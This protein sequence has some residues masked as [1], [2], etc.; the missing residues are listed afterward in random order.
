MAPTIDVSNETLERLDKMK[1]PYT[2]RNEQRQSQ[3]TEDA[4]FIKLPS[5]IYVAKEKTLHGK[6]WFDSHKALQ[7]QGNRMLMPIEFVEFLN[8][9]KDNFPEIYREITEVRSPWRAEYL[10][11]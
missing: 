3:K 4:D 8:H 10:D 5:G 2:L 9:T 1:V 7:K 11:A 6:N